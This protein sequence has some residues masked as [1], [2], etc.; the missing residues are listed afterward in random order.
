[1]QRVKLLLECGIDKNSKNWIGLT[2]MDFLLG[3]TQVDYRETL[4]ILHYAGCLKASSIPTNSTYDKLL[5][6]EISFS[7]KS[8]I[9][10]IRVRKNISNSTQQRI[11]S[12]ACINFK[13]H[14]RCSFGRF[15]QNR[16]E[17]FKI[18][19]I[20]LLFYVFDNRTELS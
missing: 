16:I 14:L 18:E 6:S 2:A 4:Q 7:E 19:L 5:R 20:E 17:L 15:D 12:S 11:T 1:M 10:L 3:Q 13:S 9:V 8:S